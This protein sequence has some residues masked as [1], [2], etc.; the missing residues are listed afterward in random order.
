MTEIKNIIL[1]IMMNFFNNYLYYNSIKKLFTFVMSFN[2]KIIPKKL[3]GHMRRMEISV[4]NK[5][6]PATFRGR[7]RNECT[8]STPRPA[9]AEFFYDGDTL[10]IPPENFWS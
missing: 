5:I 2:E 1:M 9:Q 10:P 7:G 4:L 8:D 3:T 6:N